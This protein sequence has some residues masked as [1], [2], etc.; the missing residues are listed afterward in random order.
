MKNMHNNEHGG[1][2]LG[3]VIFLAALGYAVFIGLQ[4]VPQKIE[5]M[6]LNSIL[7]SM[8]ILQQQTPAGSVQAV[9]ATIDRLLSTSELGE[10]RGNFKVQQDGNTFI[11]TVSREWKLNLIFQEK[12]MKYEKTLTLR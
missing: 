6:S 3:T 10:L 1:S 4:Y 5:D 2:A 11:V 9:E 12:L 8:H 7:D